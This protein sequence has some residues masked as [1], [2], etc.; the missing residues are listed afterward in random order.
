MAK[1]LI[2][3]RY[4]NDKQANIISDF[5]ALQTTFYPIVQGASA[6]K[7]VFLFHLRVLVKKFLAY[8]S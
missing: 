4:F 1:R 5:K 7:R 6:V 3:G 8:F 2:T